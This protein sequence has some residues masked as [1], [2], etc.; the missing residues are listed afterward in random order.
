MTQTHAA[1]IAAPLDT[2]TLKELVRVL[3]GDDHLLYRPA[4]K[5]SEFLE[6]AGW[7][8]LPEIDGESRAEWTLERLVERRTD[9]GALEDVLLRLADAREY[10]EE[11]EQL[12]RV[13]AAVNTFLV[14]EG[15]RLENPGGRPRLVPCDPALAHPGQHAPLELKATMSDIIGDE[16]M[17]ALLEHRLDEA[18]TCFANG[19]HVAATIMLGSLLEGVL[20]SAVQERDATLLGNKSPRN[21]GLQ[22]LID[23]CRKAGWIDADVTSFSHALRDYRN[24][25]HPHREYRE[26]Y[27]PD[28]D[29][30]N[31]S[32]Q[33]VNGALNDLAATRPRTTP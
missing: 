12:P 5:I 6:N 8:N 19:A 15:L 4:Y 28:R 2:N 33:V 11:P 22:E 29:T 1:A 17:A 18:R 23:I 30:F 9:P 26:A 20:L 24:F 31:V 25:I 21:I 10:Y 27:R 3:C 13:V 7:R 14:H 32:W 16:R